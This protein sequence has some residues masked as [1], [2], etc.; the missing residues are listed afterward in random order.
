PQWFEPLLAPMVQAG[1]PA[2]YRQGNLA[3]LTLQHLGIVALAS[4]A[5][6]MAGVGMA[7]FVTRRAG[8]DFL[9][10]A[11]SVVHVGQ[12]FPPVAVLALAVPAVGFGAKPT[13]IALF[14]YGLLPI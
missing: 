2:I 3:L 10:L 9:P 4:L 6:T 13:L 14:L 12:T 1:A 8:E 7:V 11:R 5:A